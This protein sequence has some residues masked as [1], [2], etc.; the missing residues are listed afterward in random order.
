VSVLRNRRILL[1]VAAAVAAAVFVGAIVAVTALGNG[2]SKTETTTTTTAGAAKPQSTTAQ[3]AGIP[4][5]GL[6][7]GWAT[8]P[9]TLVEFADP[10]CPYCAE[11]S[12]DAFAAVV[13]KFVRTGRVKLEFRGLHFIGPDSEKAL[14]AAIAAGQQGK[15]WNFVHALYAEQGAENSGW[16]T[17][18]LL[19][20]TA[21]SI[22]GLDADKLLV[23][24]NSAQVTNQIRANNQLATQYGVGGTPTFVLVRPPQQPTSVQGTSL[25]AASFTAALSAALGS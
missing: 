16:V 9:A 15:L 7:L 17:D 25:D 2:S 22:P 13:Q 19:R 14:R 23:D 5:R 24:M 21:E 8:A 1:L 12:N 18:A 11:W 20:K 10:Q 6:T 3:L 4:Q